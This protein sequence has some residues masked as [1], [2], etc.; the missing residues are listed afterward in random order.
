MTFISK[1]RISSLLALW[2]CFLKR[3]HSRRESGLNQ[4]TIRQESPRDMAFLK[5]RCNV[6]SLASLTVDSNQASDAKQRSTRD[7]NR[8]HRFQKMKLMSDTKPRKTS[9]TCRFRASRTSLSMV[10]SLNATKL[11]STVNCLCLTKVSSTQRQLKDNTSV[12]RKRSSMS[13]R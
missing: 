12:S 4:I 13:T 7:L 2:P 10:L 5:V 1:R 11:Q 8:L 9:S 6:G 3:S